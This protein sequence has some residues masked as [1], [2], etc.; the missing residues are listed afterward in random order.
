MVIELCQA[1]GN[2]QYNADIGRIE[3]KKMQ[4]LVLHSFIVYSG[5]KCLL[6][7]KATDK[8]YGHRDSNLL[9]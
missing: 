8:T 3:K 9:R 5:R 1:S 4:N 2:P 6:K 7:Y